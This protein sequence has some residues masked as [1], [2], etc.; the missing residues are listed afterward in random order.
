[1]HVE[2]D[3]HGVSGGVSGISNAPAAVLA[4]FLFAGGGVTA[5]S[6][7]AALLRPFSMAVKSVGDS[8]ME[9]R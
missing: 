9:A 8:A 3:G 1:M 7:A 4:F 5:G 6:V 2:A